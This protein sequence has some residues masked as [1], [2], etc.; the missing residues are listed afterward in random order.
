M[1]RIY[2]LNIVESKYCKG[3]Y[4]VQVATDSDFYDMFFNTGYDNVKIVE[5][6]QKKVTD[7]INKQMGKKF[8]DENHYFEE[9]GGGIVDFYQTMNKMKKTYRGS[10]V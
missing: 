9:Y 6:N 10:C 4:G 8:T 2:N 3:N 5:K 7:A 1:E